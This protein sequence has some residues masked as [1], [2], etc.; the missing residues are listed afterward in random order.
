MLSVELPN[1]RG[2]AS[3]I[4]TDIRQDE[5][6]GLFGASLQRL[7]GGEGGYDHVSLAGQPLRQGFHQPSIIVGDEEDR[8]HF[9]IA[10]DWH[11]VIGVN[12]SAGCRKGEN[13]RFQ[14]GTRRIPLFFAGRPKLSGVT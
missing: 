2:S 7:F 1:Q 12:E 10:N 14:A 6:E 5:V 9:W 8:L 4:E 3:A 11:F 13:G